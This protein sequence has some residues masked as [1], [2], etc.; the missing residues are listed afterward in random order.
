MRTLVEDVMYGRR[1]DAATLPLRGVLRFLEFFYRIAVAVRGF[2]YRRRLLKVNHAGCWTISIGNIAVGGTG[3]TPAVIMTARL[4][5]NAGHAVA[6]VSRGY[7][8][9]VAGP[10]VVSE[11]N[12]P[13]VDPAESGDEP[14]IIARACPGVPVV[15]AADR[16]MGA[17]LACRRFGTK[18]LVLDDAFQ[19]RR[20]H[21]NIDIV[22]VDAGNPYGSGHLLPRGILREPPQSLRRATAVMLTRVAD[23][24]IRASGEHMVRDYARDIP[25]FF[26]RHAPSGLRRP[27]DMVPEDVSLLNGRA[28][29]ALSNIV[30]P[31]Q[32]HAMLAD[33][34]ARVVFSRAFP[35]HH[36][37][38][39]T[40]IV[41]VEAE[42][43][44][45][46]A[47]LLVMTA[48]DELN[49][50]RSLPD[51]MERRV[52]DI[53]LEL[54]GDRDEYLKLIAPA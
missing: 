29:A 42:A 18:V 41:T 11:G 27:G 40:D 20:I 49:L 23:D 53:E 28:V 35:D 51:G 5:R 44:A 16:V 22:T 9:R 1:C 12:G 33:L 50:P 3:K 47:D 39:T 36:R 32:F 13:I 52:L 8:G 14:Q 17:E 4:L 21:R 34:G 10:L 7:G 30:R 24:T 19:H 31:E 2:L 54:L 15:T 37:Y 38:T 45:A 46:G 26:S 25:L 43:R 48:K 6:V